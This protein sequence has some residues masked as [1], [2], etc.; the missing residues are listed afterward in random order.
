[1]RTDVSASLRS[2]QLDGK[3]CCILL[4]GEAQASSAVLS[5]IQDIQP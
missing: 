5:D 2:V 3:S 4:E 1:M